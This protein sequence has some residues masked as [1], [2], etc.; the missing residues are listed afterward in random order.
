[1]GPEREKGG[2]QSGRQAWLLRGPF[3]LQPP[4]PVQ[5]SLS[6]TSTPPTPARSVRMVT[7]STCL[8]PIHLFSR[9]LSDLLSFL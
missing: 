1:M 7:L 4:S 2:F 6:C 9:V 3:L 8:R 5:K